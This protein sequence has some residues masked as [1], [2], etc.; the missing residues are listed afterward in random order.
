MGSRQ[1]CDLYSVRGCSDIWHSGLL[2]Q[3]EQ[4]LWRQWLICINLT[5]LADSLAPGLEFAFL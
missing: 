3:K 2:M 1:I 4:G 5:A